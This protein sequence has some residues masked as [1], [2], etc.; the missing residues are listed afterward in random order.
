MIGRSWTL[1][2]PLLIP[3]FRDGAGLPAINACTKMVFGGLLD[4]TGMLIRPV[5]PI[6]ND[7]AG[8]SVSGGRVLEYRFEPLSRAQPTAGQISYG[9][10]LSISL[11]C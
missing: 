6:T 3:D 4:S 5:L 2:F 1:E 9:P 11:P 8:Y 10:T 7:P